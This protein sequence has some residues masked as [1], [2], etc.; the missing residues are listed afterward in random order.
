M[1]ETT[2]GGIVEFM[3]EFGFFNVLLPFLFT[4]AIVY[5]VLDK[6][7][8]LG[9]ENDG[10]RKNI[11][12]I[13]AFVTALMLVGAT[14]LVAAINQA[15]AGIAFFLAFIVFALLAMSVLLKEGQFDFG[16]DGNKR[17]LY[18]IGGIIVF[19]VAL[20]FLH[21]LDWLMPS[22]NWIWDNI[23]SDAVTTVIFLLVVG[24]FIW[25]MSSGDSSTNGSG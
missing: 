1:Q 3:R 20:I 16:A 6:T 15:L 25:I 12:A 7:M 14:T 11:N 24:I 8:V 9:K 2:L 22:L 23:S 18:I 19:I 21:S 13:V 17:A 10:P 4:Y 5:A